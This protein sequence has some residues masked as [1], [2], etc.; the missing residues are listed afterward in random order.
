MYTKKDEYHSSVQFITALYMS[1]KN[2]HELQLTGV[3]FKLSTP[4]ILQTSHC[5][6]GSYVQSSTLHLIMMLAHGKCG[7]DPAYFAWC[8]RKQMK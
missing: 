1:Y 4:F 7:S 2:V 5:A 6:G 8:Q 3:N